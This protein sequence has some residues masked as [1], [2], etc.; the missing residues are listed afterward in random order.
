MYFS[1]FSFSQ[2]PLYRQRIAWSA[3]GKE[4]TMD[5]LSMNLDI[6][7]NVRLVGYVS[8]KKP[9]THFFRTPNE[10]I[11]YVIKSGE[12]Y[13]E[14]NGIQYTLKKNCVLLLEPGLSHKGFKES[15]CNYYYIHFKHPDLK[16]VLD[17]SPED[18]KE[19]IMAN[20]KDSL[21]SNWFSENA[22]KSYI[23]YLPKFYHCENSNELF[24][25]LNV[26]ID[27]FYSRYEN[28]TTFVSWKLSELLLK[29]CREYISTTI[30]PSQGHFS[31]AYTKS[32]K[33]MNYINSNY[34]NKISSADIQMIF[35]SNYDY[36]N[37]MFQKTTGYTIFGYLNMIRITKAK[38][39]ITSTSLKF[40][41]IAYL[42][43]IDDQYY[44]SRLFKKT[45]GMTPTQYYNDN[46]ST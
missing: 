37:R 9:W 25:I 27:D 39:L 41:E 18:I 36:L 5:L 30:V 16:R 14:E 22:P 10:Y 15:C 45:T 40:S 8:Y 26:A 38:E 2:N 24:E 13:L 20:R 43:G 31:K 42:V 3:G 6:V 44:F 17:K 35:E 19:Q 1:Y 21:K 46:S 29:L 34:S 28:Y 12:L 11:L 7:P 4:Y 23:C 33:I 32:V